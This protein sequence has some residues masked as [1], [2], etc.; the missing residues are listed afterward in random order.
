MAGALSDYEINRRLAEIA[1]HAITED[2]SDLDPPDISFGEDPSCVFIDGPDGEW[3]WSPLTDWSQ[4]GPLMERFSVRVGPSGL[5][6]DQ[7]WDA[8]IYLPEGPVGNMEHCKDP[9]RA[10]CLAIIAAHEE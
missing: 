6:G 3:C 9:R 2:C 5:T 8:S 7:G 4:L 1:G 10:I